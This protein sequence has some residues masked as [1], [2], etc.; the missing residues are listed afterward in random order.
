MTSLLTTR[1][2][3]CFV[4]AHIL[5]PGPV[6][7]SEAEPAALASYTIFW[8]RA[9]VRTTYEVGPVLDEVVVGRSRIAPF[10]L[11]WVDAGK[12]AGGVP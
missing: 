6:T 3:F 8:T 2:G 12:T 10:F 4:A 9:F 5:D 11:V 1:N 7:L